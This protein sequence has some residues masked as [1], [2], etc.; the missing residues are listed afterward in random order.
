MANSCNGTHSKESLK[1][2]KCIY[3]KIDGQKEESFDF[4]RD[5]ISYSLHQDA[6]RHNTF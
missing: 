4:I 5:Q 6:K 2:G 3:Y 1:K